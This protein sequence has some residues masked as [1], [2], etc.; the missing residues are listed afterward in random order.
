MAKK[1]ISRKI[2]P[3]KTKV[4]TRISLAVVVLLVIGIAS[5]FS[6]GLAMV[7]MVFNE[8]SEEGDGM[9]FSIFDEPSQNDGP[10]GGF[11]PE[12]CTSERPTDRDKTLK[13]EGT[14]SCSSGELLFKAKFECQGGAWEFAGYE[15]AVV[16]KSCT[17][18]DAECSECVMHARNSQRDVLS[19]YNPDDD[20]DDIICILNEGYAQDG[21]ICN[22]KPRVKGT[23]CNG[24]CVEG[25][26]P[27]DRPC[28]RAWDADDDCVPDTSCGILLDENK[29][30]CSIPDSMIPGVSLFG[31]GVCCPKGTEAK[32]F[33][34]GMSCVVSSVGWDD[35]AESAVDTIGGSVVVIPGG[36]TLIDLGTDAA[37]WASE[38]LFDSISDSECSKI[39]GNCQPSS[40][41][42]NYG[43]SDN[44]DAWRLGVS[45]DNGEYCCASVENLNEA[46][47][48]KSSGADDE[49]S[50]DD[51]IGEYES[52]E[53]MPPE[54]SSMEENDDMIGEYEPEEDAPP[55]EFFMEE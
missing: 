35:R 54:D 37:R 15:D 45:C 27:I 4:R 14:E 55:E 5:V 3:K 50:D 24:L 29:L 41:C 51:M 39:D 17:T 34:D 36:G 7:G 1:G 16:S 52:E 40:D 28:K 46:G 38:E 8:M 10:G 44:V 20:V 49:N 31:S 13:S 9:E 18:K 53:G 32:K 43:V 22:V 6:I 33:H 42:S 47:S 21:N 12:E 48:V 11:E 25:I 19:S 30:H 2:L 26:A 23:C